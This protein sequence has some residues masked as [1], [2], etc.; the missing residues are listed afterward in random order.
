MKASVKATAS[1]KTTAP[2]I[3][4]VKVP[5]QVQSA[6]TESASADSN[7]RLAVSTSEQSIVRLGKI[8]GTTMG[9]NDREVTRISVFPLFTAAYQTANT[10]L[11]T[12]RQKS[13]LALKLYVGQQVSRVISLAYPG[14][15]NA[16]KAQVRTALTELEKG[17]KLGISTLGLI[18]LAGGK[19]KIVVD[20]TTHKAKVVRVVSGGS[21]GGNQKAPIDALKAT[22]ETALTA[23]S[24]A[25]IDLEQM[26]TIIAETLITLKVMETGES[27]QVV[28]D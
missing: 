1:T 17:Q 23:A 24:Q 22:M 11:P 10:K 9:S 8:I 2:E 4:A 6:I 14:G 16:T 21:G 20:P 5:S 15:K 12:D 27:L 19:S 7:A 25:S 26:L 18:Q 3:V 13:E 28:E